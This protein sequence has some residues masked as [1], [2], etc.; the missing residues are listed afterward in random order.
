MNT[1]TKTMLNVLPE[2]MM[3]DSEKTMFKGKSKSKAN[4]G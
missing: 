3:R 4:I 2:V 1:A